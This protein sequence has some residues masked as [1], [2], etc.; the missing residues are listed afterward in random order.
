M[1]PDYENENDEG[2]VK[3][4]QV[5]EKNP[6]AN[7]SELYDGQS[8]LEIKYEHGEDTDD[9]V[10]ELTDNVKIVE[11]KKAEKEMKTD[12]NGDKFEELY[13]E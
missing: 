7:L 11:P 4:I 2:E 6:D 3:T 8:L 12:F 1:Q 13:D 9:I 10:P 5:N